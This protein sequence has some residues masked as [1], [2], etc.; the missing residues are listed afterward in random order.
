MIP[1]VNP[2]I[3][4]VQYTIPVR[5]EAET[6]GFDTVVNGALTESRGV[7]RRFVADAKHETAVRCNNVNI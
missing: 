5:M 2:S 7:V 4:E 1:P 3:T 6:I